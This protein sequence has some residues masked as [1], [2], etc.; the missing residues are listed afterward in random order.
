MNEFMIG[1]KLCFTRNSKSA[2]SYDCQLFAEGQLFDMVSEC[3]TV[4]AAE[5]A[6]SHLVVRYQEALNENTAFGDWV[7]KEFT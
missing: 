3:E 6:M 7:R 4:V 5:L 2:G 1:D